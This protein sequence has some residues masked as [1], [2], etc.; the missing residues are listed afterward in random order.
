MGREYGSRSAGDLLPDREVSEGWPES[1]WPANDAWAGTDRRS[2]NG[3][4]RRNGR[5]TPGPYGSGSRK[6]K[7]DKLPWYHKALIIVGSL[8]LV[9]SGAFLALSFRY[10][11]LTGHEDILDE[12]ISGGLPPNG[13]WNFLV[14]GTD[15]R[16][17]E[18][19]NEAALEGANSDTIML[20]HIAEGLKKAFIVSIPR[21]S[22]VYVPAPDEDVTAL[23]ATQQPGFG[24][25]IYT[26]APGTGAGTLQKVN[27]A[28]ANGGAASTAKAIWWL[29]TTR[30][31]NTD[32]TTSYDHIQLDGAVIVNFNGIQQMVDAVGGVRV[33]PPYDVPSNQP[34]ISRHY[35]QYADGWRKGQCYDMSGEEAQVFVRMRYDVP[36]GDFGRMKSQQLVMRALA[37]KATSLGV[38]ANPLALDSLLTSIA[39]SLTL[40]QSMNLRDL[41]LPL[42]GIRPNDLQFATL[43]FV[44]T[45]P[46]EGVGSSVVLD[47]AKCEELFRAILDDKTDEW[48]AANPQPD[49]ADFEGTS[50][51]G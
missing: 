45:E 36:G 8:L 20:V 23:T 49:V 48:L 42:S 13:P 47:M 51:S 33:C 31:V 37:E 3:R 29:T 14:L 38:M 12:S 25:Y 4:A 7:R 21:D 24:S 28:Y 40:D 50:G 15:S 5:R 39:Q 19:G 44:Q 10:E 16:A 27:S 35:P 11:S 32:G 34:G 6:R 2:T 26:P 18:A 9:M 30:T 22:Y 1:G 17:G 46:I 43:P 41:A